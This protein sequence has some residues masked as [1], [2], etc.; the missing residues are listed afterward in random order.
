MIAETLTA[1]E[2]EPEA[3]PAV[4]GLSDKA[5]ALDAGPIWRRLEVWA[6]VRFAVRLVTFKV[7]GPGTWAVPFEPATLV[8]AERFASGWQ[9][10]QLDPHPERPGWRLEAGLYRIKAEVGGAPP[11]VALE[12]FRR[13]A[14]YLA[15]DR[16]PAGVTIQQE[17]IGGPAG[18]ASQHM[19]RPAAWMGRAVHY[20]GAA[21]VLRPIRRAR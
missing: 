8:E 15:D 1:H 9:V 10:V 21:D 3:W 11:P 20:S 17:S 6:A 12:A 19:H 16:F 13:L 5:A 14:E 2:A 7:E 18:T 4:S